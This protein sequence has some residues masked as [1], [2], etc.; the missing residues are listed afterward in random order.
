MTYKEGRPDESEAADHQNTSTTGPTQGADACNGTGGDQ[1][2]E[3]AW[4]GDLPLAPQHVEKL[5]SSGI[6]PSIA[7]MRG[8]RTV[9]DERELRD[10]S[11][12]KDLC[13]R[14]HVPVL[15]QTRAAPGTAMPRVPQ[16]PTAHEGE[17]A[18]GVRG[19]LR[20]DPSRPGG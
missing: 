16:R 7:E 12:A 9:Y 8:Y 4:W 1:A 14:R 15:E 2:I 10:L 19:Q 17:R 6:S 3:E 18:P 20:H 13:I 11:F 5:K